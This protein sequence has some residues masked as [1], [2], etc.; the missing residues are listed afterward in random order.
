MSQQSNQ[1]QNAAPAPV[2]EAPK[3][4]LAEGLFKPYTLGS[5][6]EQG[7]TGNQMS[8]MRQSPMDYEKTYQGATKNQAVSAEELAKLGSEPVKKSVAVSKAPTD[9]QLAAVPA[10]QR[11]HVLAELD[12]REDEARKSNNTQEVDRVQKAKDRAKKCWG[13]QMDRKQPKASDLK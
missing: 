12:R 1:P 4:K 13:P 2:V 10:D 11:E 8:N 3:P 7:P 6:L 5:T 9:E